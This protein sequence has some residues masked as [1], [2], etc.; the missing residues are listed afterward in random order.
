ML[1]SIWASVIGL[2][3][4]DYYVIRKRRLNIPELF[5][6]ETDNQFTFF[7]GWNW[8]GIIALVVSLTTCYFLSDYTVFVGA[9]VTFVVYLVL[10]KF[11]FFKK[12]PQ[13]ETTAEGD[14]L[15]GTS[16]DREWMYDEENNKIYSSR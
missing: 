8:A 11:W 7:H 1:G 5:D 4:A 16:V 2:T 9:I 10:A 14:A 15:L 3:L 6:E 13:A 12:Y